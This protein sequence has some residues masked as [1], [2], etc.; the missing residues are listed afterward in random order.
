L[1]L[2]DLILGNSM[3]SWFRDSLG[4]IVFLV[5]VLFLVTSLLL[6]NGFGSLLFAVVFFLGVVFVSFGLLAQLGFFSGGFRSLGGVGTVLICMAIIFV[7]SS[8]ILFGFLSI[9]SARVV[10]SIFK[11]AVLGYKV[12]FSSERPYLWL[13]VLLMRLGIGAFGLGILFKVINAIKG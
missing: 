1:N 8:I 9:E 10:A 11:G 5:G 4:K 2:L 12:V 6:Y 7:A 13:S 3:A